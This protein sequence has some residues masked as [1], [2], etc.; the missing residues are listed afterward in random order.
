MKNPWHYRNKA[1]FPVGED[2]DGNIIAGF[3]A[4]RTHTI[5][6]NHRC[7]IGIDENQSVLETVISWM[8]EYGVRPYREADGSG[9]IRHVRL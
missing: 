1:Q 7:E 8:K 6:D 9:I 4:G 5:I 3:Y 2:R